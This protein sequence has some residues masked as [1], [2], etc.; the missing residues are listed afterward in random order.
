MYA[1][2]SR[3]LRDRESRLTI[4][5]EAHTRERHE[6]ADVA[7]KAFEFSQNLVAKWDKADYDAKRRLLEIVCLNLTLDGVSLVPEWR[8]PFD[9]LAEGL[10]LEKSRGDRI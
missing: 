5:A 9:L 10:P 6:N 2:K 8:K 3:E 7:V 4:E 1:R